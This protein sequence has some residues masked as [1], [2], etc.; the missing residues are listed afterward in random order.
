[1][2]FTRREMWNVLQ[3]VHQL[4]FFLYMHVHIILCIIHMQNMLMLLVVLTILYG[5]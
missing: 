5:T 2:T 4:T 1:M 3:C